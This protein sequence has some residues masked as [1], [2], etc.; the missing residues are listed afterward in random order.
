MSLQIMC[1]APSKIIHGT[2]LLCYLNAQIP[3]IDTA[4]RVAEHFD[5]RVNPIKRFR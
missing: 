4:K 1:H 2:V 5:H 3:V